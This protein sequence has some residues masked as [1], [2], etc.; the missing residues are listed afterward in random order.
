[1][2]SAIDN[3]GR[4]V[5]W[6]RSSVEAAVR[7]D[8]RIEWSS[9]RLDSPIADR[10]FTDRVRVIGRWDSPWVRSRIIDDAVETRDTKSFVRF[11]GELHVHA[12]TLLSW[13]REECER[14]PVFRDLTS[15]DA[16]DG[17][18]LQAIDYRKLLFDLRAGKDRASVS[19]SIRTGKY[20]DSIRT[21]KYS[22]RTRET[23]S[24]SGPN[25]PS[26][27]LPTGGPEGQF[28]VRLPQE[29]EDI[30]DEPMRS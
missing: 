15:D 17:R 22:D 3:E 7:P 20:S 5:A 14:Y 16:L 19:D 23:G 24:E 2:A 25:V 9:P 6:V 28:R 4:D 11:A 8:G 21:G 30:P 27:V 18:I 26:D 29:R 10:L 13:L 1:M 12:A